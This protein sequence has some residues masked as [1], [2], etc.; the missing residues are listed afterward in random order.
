MSRPRVDTLLLLYPT[1][2]ATQDTPD[3]TQTSNYTSNSSAHVSVSTDCTLLPILQKTQLIYR[4]MKTV[5]IKLYLEFCIPTVPLCPTRRLLIHF[6]YGLCETCAS[7]SCS[8]AL[9]MACTVRSPAPID[10]AQQ[11]RHGC[12]RFLLS[13]IA[14]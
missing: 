1:G 14:H 3:R 10:L 13:R 11:I 12:T 8:P 6:S 4:S 9:P 5:L 2:V 7:A